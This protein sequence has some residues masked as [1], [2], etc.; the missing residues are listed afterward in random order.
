ML[1][2]PPIIF[3]FLVTLKFMGLTHKNQNKYR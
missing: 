2:K 3:Q 1:Q